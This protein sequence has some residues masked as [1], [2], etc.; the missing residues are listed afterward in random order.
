MGT[1][2]LSIKYK[3]NNAQ[4]VRSGRQRISLRDDR[5]DDSHE[6][7]LR[8]PKSRWFAPQ[9]DDLRKELQMARNALEQFQSRT[10]VVAPTASGADTK[11]A[12]L[13][14]GITGDLAETRTPC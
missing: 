2:V 8:G 9:L 12:A 6:G 5:R 11:S 13:S 3:S 1:N 10:N 7:G 4:S 14:A